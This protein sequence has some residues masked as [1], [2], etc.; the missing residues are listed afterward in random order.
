V[1]VFHLS[2]NTVYGDGD[3][4]VLTATRT[5]TSLAS[6]A[7]STATTSVVVP[8]STSLGTYYFCAMA[9]SGNTVSE[10]N[11]TN[12]TR[13]ILP[14]I[15]VTLP[16]LVMSVLTPITFTVNAGSTLSVTN[17]VVNQGLVASGSFTIAFHLSLNSIYGDG[18]DVVITTTRY[19]PILPAGALNSVI[20]SLLIPATTPAGNYYVCAKADSGGTVG[21]IDETNNSLCSTLQVTVPQSDLIVSAVSTTA[22]LVNTGSTVSVSNSV[23]NQGGSSAGSSVVAFHL[24]TNTVYGDGDDVVITTTRAITSVAVGATS[25]AT[26]PVVI[27]ASTPLGTY[28]LCAMAD[29]GNTVS[30]SIETNNTL[31]TSSTIQVTQPDMVMSAVTPNAA[32]VN[33]GSALSVTNTAGNQGL[34]AS[35]SF[36]IAFH[37]SLNSIYGDGDDVVIT[38]TRTVSSLAAGGLNSA[39]TSLVIPAATPSGVY[40]VCAKADSGGTV[41]EI[42]ETNN[43]L[44]STLQVTVPQSDLIVSAISTTATV[45]S[46]GGSVSVSNSVK[47]QG[48]SSAGSSVVAFHLSTN[49]VY[50]DGDDI[51]MTATRTIT[52]VAVGATSTA[53]A[54]V[55]IPASTPLGTYYLCA[56]ADSGNTVS[57]S[58]ESNNT[59]CTSSTIQVTQPDMVI[60]AVTPNAATVNAGSTL[61]VTNTAGNQG[62]VASGSFVIAFHLSLNAIYGDGDDVVM[63][64]TR[65]VSSLAAGGSNSA[66]TSLLIPA[67]TLSG[68]Y[69]V[70]AKADSGGTVTET[71]ETNNSLCSIL[72][73]TVP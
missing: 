69:N 16:D 42:D 63:T 58:N 50:G 62:L 71:D 13:C 41:S 26:A 2:T 20:T 24:S 34:V 68:V 44:C 56:M 52:S 72:Q 53:T 51:V 3:D 11:E 35:G 59:L 37:L 17:T 49:A 65:T 32:T 40:N 73:V 45:V 46:T 28:Y 31:C 55:V 38:T 10:S 36:V 66:T 8:A 43:S 4:I 39:T 29:S 70:C 7:T 15:Q 48:G 54:P 30:E 23:K 5:I 9:D 25:T 27:P 18:D 19:S 57:E 47:D 14:P 60:S 22:T 33:A 64:T 67:T 61:S 6:G 1:V 21:E 12:N